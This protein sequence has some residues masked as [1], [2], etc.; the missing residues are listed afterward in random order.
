MFSSFFYLYSEMTTHSKPVA[1]HKRRHVHSKH[2]HKHDAGMSP[3]VVVVDLE[4]DKQSP[5][6]KFMQ[7]LAQKPA[8]TAVAGLV[9]AFPIPRIFASN[10]VPFLQMMNARKQAAEAEEEDLYDEFEEGVENQLVG[11]HSAYHKPLYDLGPEPKPADTRRPGPRPRPRPRNWER[12]NNDGVQWASEQ[13]VY[14]DWTERSGPVLKDSEPSYKEAKEYVN[15]VSNPNPTVNVTVKLAKSRNKRRSGKRGEG[16]KLTD[17][18]NYKI[19]PIGSSTN[20]TFDRKRGQAARESSP[21]SDSFSDSVIVSLP[22]SISVD[23][24]DTESGCSDD[25]CI[26]SGSSG[27]SG[28]ISSGS[29][30]S[31]WESISITDSDEL[32]TEPDNEWDLYE[33]E[34]E[35]ESFHTAHRSLLDNIKSRSSRKA[36]GA[37]P[38]VRR[39][40]NR[41]LQE[42]TAEGC[43]SPSHL[44]F[45]LAALA[46][47]RDISSEGSK[48]LL[49][50]FGSQTNVDQA[51]DDIRR[52]NTTRYRN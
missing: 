41:R 27:S 38:K 12:R 5:Q 16:R 49:N 3:E 29:G 18:L 48:R 20:T 31:E 37:I 15:Q 50:A 51:V 24:S 33:N 40:Y 42:M 46:L 32:E 44:G 23:T 2:G 7:E 22:E 26:S 34:D 6:S 13:P 10:A 19:T 9:A 1:Y 30:D 8:L 39:A 36:E 43:D 52:G 45:I 25:N 11:P 4:V 47:G 28:S 35:T 14:R 21:D 17:P